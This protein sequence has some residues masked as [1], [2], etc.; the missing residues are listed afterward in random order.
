[1]AE[2]A[3]SRRREESRALM[4]R[5]YPRADRIV[6]VSRDL[7]A[8]L[9]D[10]AGI[11]QERITALY[12]AVVDDDLYAAAKEEPDHPWLKPGAPPVILGV[13]RL[14]PRKGF[15]VLLRAFA[16][17]LRNRPARLIILGHGKTTDK[18]DVCTA[19]LNALTQELGIANAVSLPGFQR[20]PFAYMARARVFVLPSWFE[21]LP[22]VLI[23]AMACGCPVVSTDCPTGPR[24]ILEG[25]RHGPLVPVGDDKAMAAAIEG[26]LNAPP[27]AVEPQAL[28]HLYS[29][30]A[31]TK[32]YLNLFR[33][34]SSLVPPSTYATRPFD[35]RNLS[36]GSAA[37][38]CERRQCE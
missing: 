26:V 16:R 1:M 11:P 14:V 37:S 8:E 28:V 32:S 29:T 18:G 35:R 3:R 6:T 25:G 5:Y 34:I 10:F 24:E 27:P 13:G 7:A 36:H 9:R 19:E 30:A 2:Y 15:D 31:A 33:E 38:L 17:V 4:R 23:Q 12:N 21:G 20:N 22:G